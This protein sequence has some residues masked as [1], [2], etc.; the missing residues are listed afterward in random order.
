MAK[1]SNTRLPQSDKE[2]WLVRMEEIPENPETCAFW[3][4]VSGLSLAGLEE[5]VEHQSGYKHATRVHQCARAIL[6]VT[7][8]AI[9]NET[10]LYEACKTVRIPVTTLNGWRRRMPVVNEAIEI[11]EQTLD[12]RV[13]HEIYDRAV[14]GWE[15]D[16]W[17][18]GDVVGSKRVKSHDLL[19][20]H[21]QANNPKY[22]AKQQIK[23]EISGPGNGAV[24]IDANL[25]RGMSD[26][27]LAFLEKMM[28][29]KASNV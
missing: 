26:E 25:L 3:E 7:A 20:F 19:K 1:L 9:Y 2:P 14:N 10:T 23:Q 27:E 13:E 11:V 29:K 16:V 12:A 4:E 15:E 17:H 22:A 6:M 18:Q 5:A 8:T 28:E 21:A 24:Q